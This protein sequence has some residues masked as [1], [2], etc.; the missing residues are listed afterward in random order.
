[1]VGDQKISAGKAKT[2]RAGHH[3][4]WSLQSKE[5]MEKKQ[6]PGDS[7]VIWPFQGVK[8]PPTRDDKGTLNHQVLIILPNQNLPWKTSTTSHHWLMLQNNKRTLTTTSQSNPSKRSLLP[9]FLALSWFGENYPNER[10][11]VLEGP[12]FHFHDDGRKGRSIPTTIIYSRRRRLTCLTSN[13][14]ARSRMGAKSNLKCAI[15]CRCFPVK[16]KTRALWCFHIQKA[17]FIPLST[18][19]SSRI[20]KD[21]PPKLAILQKSFLFQGQSCVVIYVKSPV[22]TLRCTTNDSRLQLTDL[23]PSCFVWDF[24][25]RTRGPILFL[26]LGWLLGSHLTRGW[27]DKWQ[28]SKDWTVARYGCFLKWWYPQSPPQND[29]F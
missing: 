17:K 22:C 29:H 27:L 26:P 24:L 18:D 5:K 7:K 13:S 21:K 12:A 11:L 3:T 9:P 14:F 8:W 1:M 15:S 28:L 19:I 25:G 16:K 6:F 4:M 20:S 23:F 2:R 10:K